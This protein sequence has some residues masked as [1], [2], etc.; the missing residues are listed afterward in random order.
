LNFIVLSLDKNK[1]KNNN[2][3]YKMIFTSRTNVLL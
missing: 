1:L 2:N 3:Q